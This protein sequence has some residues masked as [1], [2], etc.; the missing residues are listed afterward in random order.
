MHSIKVDD[1][2]YALLRRCIEIEARSL[3]EIVD[4]LLRP[5]LAKYSHNT[6]ED[7]EQAKE[8][9]EMDE[10]LRQFGEESGFD[11]NHIPF[12]RQILGIRRKLDELDREISSKSEADPELEKLRFSILEALNFAEKE[13]LEKEQRARALKSKKWAEVCHKIRIDPE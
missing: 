5:Y 13:A 2:L 10:M 12:D 3:D 6:L 4:S 9:S 11:P 7:W 8:A 1:T